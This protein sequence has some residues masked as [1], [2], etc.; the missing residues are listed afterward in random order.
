[1]TK[2][3]TGQDLS[4]L[5]DE[6]DTLPEQSQRV[7]NMHYFEGISK[8]RIAELLDLTSDNVSKII[9][10]S[11]RELKKTPKLKGFREGSLRMHRNAQRSAGIRPIVSTDTAEEEYR[12]LDEAFIDLTGVEVDRTEKDKK[13]KA[14]DEEKE[15]GDI[16]ITLDID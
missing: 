3:K 6:I 11:I 4:A 10:Q 12:A 7:I 13:K 9:N 14:K 16:D 8:N 5:H 1:M 15:K 2:D